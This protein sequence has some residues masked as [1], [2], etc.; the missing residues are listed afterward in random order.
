MSRQTKNFNKLL[1]TFFAVLKMNLLFFQQA[2]KVV[3]VVFVQGEAIT[4][5]ERGNRLSKEPNSVDL[6]I[7]C[8]SLAL[9]YTPPIDRDLKATILSNRSLM[10]IKT[11]SYDDALRDAHQCVE[12]TPSWAKVNLG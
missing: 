10:Y 3:L 4:W 12:I 6:A 7:A 9:H 8:Y 5:K 1:Q 11:G 2:N